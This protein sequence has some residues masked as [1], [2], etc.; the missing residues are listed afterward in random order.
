MSKEPETAQEIITF[1]DKLLGKI[2]ANLEENRKLQAKLLPTPSLPKATL[3][4]CNSALKTQREAKFKK[5]E[6][7][8]KLAKIAL[9]MAIQNQAK[10][11][12]EAKSA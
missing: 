1:N 5:Q 7:D 11:K 8:K 6:D 9:E 2:S 10:S 4:Q 12:A 3:Q